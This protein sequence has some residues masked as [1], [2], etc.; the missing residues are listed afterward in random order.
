MKK[1]EARASQFP[2][3]NWVD[4]K[5]RIGG[6]DLIFG[7]RIDGQGVVSRSGSRGRNGKA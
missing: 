3:V 5:K 7:T 6:I 2:T 1:W 4:A